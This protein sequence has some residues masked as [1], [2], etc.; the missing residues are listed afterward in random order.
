MVCCTSRVDNRTKAARERAVGETDAR[1]SKTVALLKGGATKSLYSEIPNQ[2]QKDMNV[3]VI[4]CNL[5]IEPSL[6]SL[7]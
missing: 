7:R 3:S 1:Q 6:V 5:M 4:Q 2:E